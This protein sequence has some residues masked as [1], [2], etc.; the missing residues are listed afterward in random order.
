MQEKRFE[1]HAQNIPANPLCCS[2]HQGWSRELP[3]RS[4][5]IDWFMI[6]SPRCLAT[7]FPV[8][9]LAAAAS[10]PGWAANLS[11]ISMR[12]NGTLNIIQ[13]GLDN[14]C[15]NPVGII[16]SHQL[17]IAKT[18]FQLGRHQ[19]FSWFDMICHVLVGP[20]STAPASGPDSLQF[21]WDLLEKIEDVPS[22]WST[23]C[24]PP[25]RPG[26]HPADVKIPGIA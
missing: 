2:L 16:S 12:H 11:S 5:I 9:K 13:G 8:S 10:W 22:T 26:R 7:Y 4:R 23:S 25:A 15:G 18:H 1:S 6:Q 24:L 20:I 21:K 3:V 19:W 17:H 14:G